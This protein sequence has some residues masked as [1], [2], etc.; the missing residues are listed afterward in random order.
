MDLGV[1]QACMSEGLEDTTA[2]MM[3]LLSLSLLS[4]GPYHV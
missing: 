4:L 3:A 1:L 2:C